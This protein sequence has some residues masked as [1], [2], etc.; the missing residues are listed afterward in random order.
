[1]CFRRD[2][3]MNRKNLR[4][5]KRH[6]TI[7]YPTCMK[8]WKYYRRSLIVVVVVVAF[9]VQINMCFS[10]A[11]LKVYW[12]VCLQHVKQFYTVQKDTLEN[13]KIY[14]AHFTYYFNITILIIDAI[15]LLLHQ[16]YYNYD[17]GR[18][19][20]PYSKNFLFCFCVFIIS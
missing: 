12:L 3:M 20:L 15:V 8:Q 5:Y 14:V 2:K 17:G 9:S 1:M 16:C 6:K 4:V 10:I 13:E 18:C 19:D 7:L 11:M